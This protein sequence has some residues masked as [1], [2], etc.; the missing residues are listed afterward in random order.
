MSKLS[1]KSHISDSVYCSL[2]NC[3]HFSCTHHYARTQGVANRIAMEPLFGT[4]YCMDIRKYKKEDE[5]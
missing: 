5:I 1:R 4:K 2:I 3:E